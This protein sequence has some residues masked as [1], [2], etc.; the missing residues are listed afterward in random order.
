MFNSL[1]RAHSHTTSPSAYAAAIAN[2][3]RMYFVYYRTFLI[4]GLRDAAGVGRRG[5]RR[6]QMLQ[7]QDQIFL[8]SVDTSYDFF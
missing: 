6:R 8:K 7:T 5:A 3:A 2:L 1:A 4:D